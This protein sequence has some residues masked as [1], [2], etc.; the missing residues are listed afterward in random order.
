MSNYSNEEL[1][2][3]FLSNCQINKEFLQIKCTSIDEQDM[4]VNISPEER[5]GIVTSLTSLLKEKYPSLLHS[6]NRDNKTL[7]IDYLENT[8]ISGK[9]PA[10]S[11]HINETVDSMI[12]F[13]FME[14]ST[15]VDKWLAELFQLTM[16]FK[17]CQQVQY[18]SIVETYKKLKKMDSLEARLLSVVDSYKNKC[19]NQLLHYNNI[20]DPHQASYYIKTFGDELGLLETEAAK[21]DKLAV[22]ITVSTSNLRDKLYNEIMKIDDLLYDIYQVLHGNGLTD[23]ENALVSYELRK[24]LEKHNMYGPNYYDSD[25]GYITYSTTIRVMLL[26]N[27]ITTSQLPTDNSKSNRLSCH[28]Q[29]EE[30]YYCDQDEEPYYSDQ[31][32]FEYD[33]ETNFSD[34]KKEEHHYSDQEKEEFE[35]RVNDMPDYLTK[36]LNEKTMIDN[37]SLFIIVEKYDGKVIFSVKKQRN[38]K[39][40]FLWGILNTA[41][42]SLEEIN[43]NNNLE[44]VFHENLEKI[45]S[46][47]LFCPI[48][49]SKHYS[50]PER[51]IPCKNP[52][53]IEQFIQ[54]KIFPNVDGYLY[55]TPEYVD[56]IIC[57]T[58]WALDDTSEE[59]K[60]VNFNPF[61]LQLINKGKKGY[62]QL[63]RDIEHI[64]SVEC[65]TQLFDSDLFDEYFNENVETK[66]I[67]YVLEWILL[68]N[69]TNLRYVKSLSPY[70]ES[71][72][73]GRKPMVFE[74]ISDPQD[75][76]AFKRESEGKLVETVYHGSN[77]SFWHG[78]LRN[79]LKIYSN[80]KLQSN[81]CAYGPGV[82]FS[83][84]YSTASSYQKKRK[85]ESSQSNQSE[86]W[87]Q[88]STKITSCLLVADFINH[89]SDNKSTIRMPADYRIARDTKYFI[90]RYLLCYHV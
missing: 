60:D 38:P 61:P 59:R 76:E 78:I 18:R 80:T 68:S 9:L 31:E 28:D 24:Y 57:I 46:F 65:L 62:E 2:P 73:V 63:R 58:Y 64:P 44:N 8:A 45:Y 11:D 7:S 32:E 40:R 88:S 22:N 29:E 1:N 6:Y 51:V 26:M 71:I 77:N 75:E 67:L 23:E 25:T 86:Y 70:Q 81:G 53:C 42:K 84:S 56:I 89:D 39:L 49:G 15:D 52:E 37:K 87:P 72:I 55:D 74:I 43:I 50:N 90:P 35:I 36:M 16:L 82:Y 12:L 20:V 10:L 14:A 13:I 79:G 19:F 54:K 69:N 27:I 85:A 17:D 41:C 34:N 47:I 4:K 83:T 21:N 66:E 30:F 5:K 48:C 33:S 3:L